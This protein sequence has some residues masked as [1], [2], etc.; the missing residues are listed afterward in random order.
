MNDPH[1]WWYVTRASAVLAWIVMTVAVLWGILLSTRVFRGADNPA[2]LQDLHRFLGGLALTLTGIHMVSLMLDPWL[3]MPLDQLLVPLIAEYRPVP[4]ALG[5]LAFYVLLAV[6][7]TSLIMNRLPRRF[8]KAVHYLSYV[9]VLAVAVHGALAGTDA[10]AVWYQLVATVIV[11]ASVLA[12]AVRLVMARRAR[13]ASAASNPTP[14]LG[15]AGVVPSLAEANPADPLTVRRM[16]V[17]AKHPVADGVVRLRLARV[18]GQP[19]DPWYAGAHM[20]LRL[21][22]GIE[23]Q[24]S[25]CSD[26]A[27]RNHVDIAVLRAEPAGAG[28]TYLHDVVELG[29]ELDA[30]GPRNHFPLEAAHDYLF[31]AGGIGITPIR[32]MIEALPPTRT[33]RLLYLGRTRSQLAFAAELEQR[34]GDR[35]QIVAGD[36]RSQ[37]IDL[38]QVIGATSPATAVYACGSSTLLDDVERATPRERCHTERFIAAD[39]A[40]GVERAPVTVIAQRSGRSIA[41]P[42]DQSILAALQGAGLPVATSCGTGV[43]GTCETRVLRGTPLHLDS[44]MPDADKDEVGV[45]YPCVSR[46]R[47]PELVLDV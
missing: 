45:F 31:I 3:A 24:Y 43:C 41:V 34:Y 19:I 40:T 25:L 21:P 29:D 7:L 9:A 2:W 26:P 38:A 6:Q 46:A 36:E 35:V 23:R 17:I 28:S 44:V 20:T 33:W 15:G 18:D 16:R 12:L 11:T 14:V 1:F 30:I 47:T 5:I 13:S 32:A 42:A 37:R 22:I 4:V 39:R 10:G 27:D 8:W